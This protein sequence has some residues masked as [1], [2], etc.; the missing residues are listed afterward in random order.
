MK[1]IWPEGLVPHTFKFQ[2][3]RSLKQEAQEFKAMDYIARSHLKK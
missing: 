1:K 2:L 3:F